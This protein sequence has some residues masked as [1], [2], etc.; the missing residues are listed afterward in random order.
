MGVKGASERLAK[1]L[2][3]LERPHPPGETRSFP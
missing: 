1:V 3:K 2:E